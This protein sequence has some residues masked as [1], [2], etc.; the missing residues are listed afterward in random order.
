MGF[1]EAGGGAGGGPPTPTAKAATTGG[2]PASTYDNGAS[3]QGAKLTAGANGAIPP[4]D[5][6][7][8][9]TCDFI[10][11]KNQAAPLENGYYHVEDGGSPTAPWV[12][13][14]AT[15]ANESSEF[16]IVVNVVG[17]TQAGKWWGGSLF[18]DPDDGGL[19]LP[20][21]DIGS[22]PITW[23]PWPPKKN[24]HQHQGFERVDA[25]TTG[26]L[27]AST[28]ANGNSGRGATLTADVNGALP[29]QDTITLTV[30]EELL[31]RNQALDL[32]NGVYVVSQV[33]DGS[34]PWIL[35]R[36]HLFAFD[37]G[38][39]GHLVF[40]L[41]GATVARTTFRQTT[42]NPDVGVDSIVYVDE[43]LGAPAAHDLGGAEHNADTLA[44]L[45][46]KVSDATLIDTAD[47]RLS[48]ART[49]TA[50]DL[51]GAEHNADTLA[52]L[53][54]KVSDATLIDTNDPRLGSSAIV[55]QSATV[56]TTDTTETTLDSFTLVDETVVEVFAWIMGLV[57]GGNAAGYR[58]TAV[59]KRVA[60]G[61]AALIGG[62]EVFLR[63][64]DG[65][66]AATLDVSGNDVRVR[67]TGVAATTIDWRVEWAI[68]VHT[69]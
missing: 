7:S 27:P 19:V 10:V 54:A 1:F 23:T 2:L 65:N 43:S 45:N 59:A 16:P 13:T 57:N 68:R 40:V 3:G 48:D 28:Y 5:G 58:V 29:A 32:E 14:R 66:W 42:A 56:Q 25:S 12:L 55:R 50:H 22:D 35:R 47:A 30:G 9:G 33:G 21:P 38:L 44:N 36:H 51:A 11:V 69:P 67:V 4:I 26:P 17:G 41:A 60:A 18:G 20:D 62:V 49:P 61:G 39:D 46:A 63:E 53:N 31:V 64:D 37:G 6:Q 8:V 24:K 52:N 15:S 34:N